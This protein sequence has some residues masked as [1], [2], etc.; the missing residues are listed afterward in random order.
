MSLSMDNGDRGLHFPNVMQNVVLDEKEDIDSATILSLKMVE[1]IAKDTKLKRK[2]AWNRHAVS[3]QFQF[4][5]L[6]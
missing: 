6:N 3:I 5:K 4:G 2:T 1:E